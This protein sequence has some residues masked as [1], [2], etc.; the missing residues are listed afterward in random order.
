M[1]HNNGSLP[2]LWTAF[3][4]HRLKKKNT[5]KTLIVGSGL[6]LYTEVLHNVTGKCA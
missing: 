6:S 1:L 2:C 4:S 3:T 5:Q